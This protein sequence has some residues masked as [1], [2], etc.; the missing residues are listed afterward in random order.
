MYEW[1]VL[2]W[3][4]QM[5]VKCCVGHNLW[6]G[7]EQKV[8]AVHACEYWAKATAMQPNTSSLS[9]LQL[10]T[11]CVSLFSKDN[12]LIEYMTLTVEGGIV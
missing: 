9:E 1:A 3:L 8:T 11:E 4:P 2:V 10:S 12:Y 7:T 6:L 5:R